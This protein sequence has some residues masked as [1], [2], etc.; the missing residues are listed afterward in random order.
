MTEGANRFLLVTAADSGDPKLSSTGVVEIVFGSGTRH[1]QSLEFNQQAYKADIP[2]S[3]LGGQ[4]VVVCLARRYG[5][6]ESDGIT[7]NIVAGNELQAF[8]IENWS[9]KRKVMAVLISI[10]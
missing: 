8:G 4:L 5:N 2:E 10:D 6:G 9:G 1:P 3:A 7:Y